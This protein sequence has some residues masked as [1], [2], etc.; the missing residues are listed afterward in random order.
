MF[1]NPFDSFHNT[2]A[3]AKE[4]REQLDRLLTISTPRE[5][6]L[7]AAIAAL[8]VILLA[9]LFFGNVHRSVAL[10]GRLVEPLES[11][12]A[13]SF[14]VQAIVWVRADVVSTLAPGMPALM[15]LT[16][17]EGE[18]DTVGG[19]VATVAPVPLTDVAFES[20]VSI[21]RI[22]IAL[23]DGLDYGSLAARD[24]RLVIEI[25]RQSPLALFGLRRS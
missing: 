20:P 13:G 18:A 25:G 16:A 21:Y 17:K 19:V 9:W 24:C 14:S 23:D 10:D 3:E 12:P 8:L 15:E 1:N 11:M 4:E 2:V 5:R 7:V 22:G 6:L